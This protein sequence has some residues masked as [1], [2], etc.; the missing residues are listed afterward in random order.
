[1]SSFIFLHTS[2]TWPVLESMRVVAGS[3]LQVTVFAFSSLVTTQCSMVSAEGG[4][5]WLRMGAG[6][7]GVCGG[8]CFFA[9]Q[10]VSSIHKTSPAMTWALIP[11]VFALFR[12]F[13]DGKLDYISG[14]GALSEESISV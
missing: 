3:Q 10:A 14:A 9:A 12:R 13:V 6:G 7:G 1:M 5:S 8:G 11:S 4:G 2:V